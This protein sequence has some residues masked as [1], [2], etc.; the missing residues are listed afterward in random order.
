MDAGDGNDYGGF[1]NLNANGA[2]T[3]VVSIPRDR[4]DPGPRMYDACYL[5]PASGGRRRDRRAL[6]RVLRG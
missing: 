2:L 3:T 4:T 1:A 5:K 6:D